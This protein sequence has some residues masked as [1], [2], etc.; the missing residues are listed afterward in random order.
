MMTMTHRV[1]LQTPVGRL[2]TRAAALR[3]AHAAAMDALSRRYGRTMEFVKH[4]GG[5]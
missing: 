2:R 1:P 4:E 5:A 3:Q